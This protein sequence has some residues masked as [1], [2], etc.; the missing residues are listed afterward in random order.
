[1]GVDQ[2]AAAI[3]RVDGSIGLNVRLVCVRI[4]LA[5]HRADGAAGVCAGR[6]TAENNSRKPGVN[7]KALIGTAGRD[8]ISEPSAHECVGSGW[9]VIPPW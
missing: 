5:V 2:R 7:G 3:S 6:K 4:E 1:M 9:N 8:Q